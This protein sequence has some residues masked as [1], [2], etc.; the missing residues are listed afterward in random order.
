MKG[1]K[2]GPN[3]SSRIVCI[4]HP[5]RGPHLEASLR[6]EIEGCDFRAVYAEGR[7]SLLV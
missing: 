4:A 2:V 6:G 7:A 1:D 3:E 5:G